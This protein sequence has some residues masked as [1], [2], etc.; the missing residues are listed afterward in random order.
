MHK[1]HTL[2]ATDLGIVSSTHG[3]RQ[4]PS[5]MP[6]T[7]LIVVALLVF[8]IKS[9]QIVLF[10]VEKCCPNSPSTRPRRRPQI[11]IV[12]IDVKS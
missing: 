7:S 12:V 6:I 5:N 1:G 3:G 10:E 4:H 11:F 2:H 9:N 8:S